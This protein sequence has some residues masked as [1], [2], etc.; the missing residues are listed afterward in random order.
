MGIA[1]LG[2][3]G[4]RLSRAHS[5]CRV[6]RIDPSEHAQQNGCIAHRTAHRSGAILAVGD[7]DNPGTTHQSYR[8]LNAGKAVRG[9]RAHDGA[10]C[11]GA[12]PDR[13]EICGDAGARTGAGSASIAVERIG[14]FREAATSTPAAGRMTGTD[15]GPF[16]EIRFAE[17]HRAGR[18]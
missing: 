13:S 6:Y 18:T 1:V 12:N 4:L 11:F 2:I 15:V 7:R 16:A 5:L 3:I 9:R 17:N 14:I 8:R 10:V